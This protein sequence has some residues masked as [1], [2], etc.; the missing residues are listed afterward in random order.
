MTWSSPYCSYSGYQSA[1]IA[2]GGK[3]FV[4]TPVVSDDDDHSSQSPL[5]PS[6][7]PYNVLSA[8]A[9]RPLFMQELGQEN[10]SFP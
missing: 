4:S 2:I 9:L 8:S 6:S 5:Q 10:G 7:K 1:R 3:L